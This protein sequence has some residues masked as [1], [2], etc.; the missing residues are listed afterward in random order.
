[1]GRSNFKLNHVGDNSALAHVFDRDH[2]DQ[3]TFSELSLQREILQ[4]FLLQ[5]ENT[6]TA[7]AKGPTA[8]DWRYISHTLKGAAAA[9]GAIAIARLAEEWESVEPPS[10]ADALA[11]AISSYTVACEAFTQAIQP[12]LRR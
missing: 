5:I 9:V 4:L 3:Q 8:S 2:F 11:T 7:L 10:G 1:M 6:K 12:I